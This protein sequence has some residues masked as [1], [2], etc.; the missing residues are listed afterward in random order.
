MKGFKPFG[1]LICLGVLVGLACSAAGEVLSP[2]EATQRAI[3]TVAATQER[4]S[5]LEAAF[6]INDVAEIVGTQFLILLRNTP[7]DLRTFATQAT[8]GEQATI[9][10]YQEF[11]GKQWYLVKVSAGQGW[12]QAE[13]LK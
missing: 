7:G 13:N 1:W 4:T 2:E 6:A 12:V 8:R 5:G 10:D 11:D 3:P 9:L